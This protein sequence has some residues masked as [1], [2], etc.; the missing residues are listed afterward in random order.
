[1]AKKVTTKPN[2]FY[3]GKEIKT[4][5]DTPLEAL[6]FIYKIYNLDNQMYYVGR[7]TI[8]SNRRRKLTVAEKKIKGNEK[9]TFITEMKE[10]SGWKTYAGSNVTL[11]AEVTKGARIRKEILHYCY[12]KAEI[13]YKETAEILCSGALLDIKSYNSWVKAT[14]YKKHLM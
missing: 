13:T 9:K 11:K 2:W 5:A 7:R 6:G 10:S 1:M 8:R 14:I 3:Q 12:S 4:L